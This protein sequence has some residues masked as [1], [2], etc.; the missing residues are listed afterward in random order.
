[1]LIKNINTNLIAFLVI[2]SFPNEMLSEAVD[3]T[4]INNTTWVLE[5]MVQ[6]V[7]C[8]VKVKLLI[9]CLA[10]HIIPT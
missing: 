3:E 4:S 5:K 7:V 6:P 9:I 8:M 1:M 2:I 10:M